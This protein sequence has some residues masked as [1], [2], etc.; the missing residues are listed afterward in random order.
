MRSESMP[1]VRGAVLTVGFLKYGEA[2]ANM[3]EK[4]CPFDVPV[5]GFYI[6]AEQAM[7]E[8]E[9]WLNRVIDCRQFLVV[10]KDL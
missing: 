9:G 3:L 2:C 1:R 4:L 5:E 6:A 10:E 7:R 8:F